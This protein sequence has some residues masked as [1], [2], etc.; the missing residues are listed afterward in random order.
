MAAD[1]L[2]DSVKL[3][4]CLEAEAD[5]IRSKT[6]G[7]ADI[8]FDFSGE[9]GFSAAMADLLKPTGTKSITANGTVDVS[10]FASAN[11]NVQTARVHTGSATYN[12]LSTSANVTCGFAPD[13]VVYST[14]DQAIQG[15]YYYGGVDF[16]SRTSNVACLSSVVPYD[17]TSWYVIGEVFSRTSNGFTFYSMNVFNNTKVSSTIKYVAI[18]YT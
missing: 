7:S 5:T 1:K 15:I 16:R 3:D 6:G 2:I 12:S 14:T 10:A 18:K 8:T 4:A 9:T 17:E 11:V 13:V